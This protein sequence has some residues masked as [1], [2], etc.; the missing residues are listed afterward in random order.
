MR[1]FAGVSSTSE[2]AGEAD[3]ADGMLEAG[4]NSDLYR[5]W[6][7]GPNLATNG[8]ALVYAEVHG[9][10]TPWLATDNLGDKLAK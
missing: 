10:V 7:S 4:A 6:P 8:H 3:I 9:R 2:V 5:K 1:R